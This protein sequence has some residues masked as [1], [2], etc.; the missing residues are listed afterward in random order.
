MS[1]LMASTYRF[2]LY[3]LVLIN[4]VTFIVYGNDKKKAKQKKWRTSEAELIL[5]AVCGGAY[6]AYLGMRLFHHKTKHLK[7]MILVPL[8]VILWTGLIFVLITTI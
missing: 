6:G 2:L 8:S 4:I 7:F 1:D 3:Y 5:L